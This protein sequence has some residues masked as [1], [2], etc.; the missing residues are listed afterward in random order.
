M[1]DS[2][3][4]THP[5]IKFLAFTVSTSRYDVAHMFRAGVDGYITKSTFGGELPGFVR[6]ALDGERPISANV[7]GHLLDI[8]ADFEHTSRLEG[9][10]DREREVTLL[11]ARG[12]TY[13]EI[14]NRLGIS[15]KTVE[16]H[17]RNIFEKLGVASRH[18]LSA[19][20][21]DTG[22]VE[23]GYASAQT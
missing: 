17:M 3:R 21:Y 2:V 16:A 12:Y 19:L 11:I 22:F 5:N 23:P 15:R 10:T 4:K 14:G 8:D 7:A 9:L 1:L 20:A 6:A 13:P 18:E